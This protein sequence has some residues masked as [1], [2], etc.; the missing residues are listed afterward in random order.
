MLLLGMGRAR[1][2]LDSNEMKMREI[3]LI[4]ESNC[5]RECVF[6][7]GVW[8]VVILVNAMTKWLSLNALPLK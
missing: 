3:D 5:R 8:I 1:T 7:D 4:V 6:L 2:T